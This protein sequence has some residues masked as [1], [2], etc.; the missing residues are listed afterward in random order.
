MTKASSLF[1][2]ALQVSSTIMH[3][4]GASGEVV[5]QINLCGFICD[6]TGSEGTL[7]FGIKRVDKDQIGSL[8][9]GDGN[10]SDNATNR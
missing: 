7:K 2:P 10:G 6:R 4:A 9:N 5:R 1:K 3:K 8:R